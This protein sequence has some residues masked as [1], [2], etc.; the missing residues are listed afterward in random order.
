MSGMMHWPMSRALLL[1]TSFV[2]MT[3]VSCSSREQAA[4]ELAIDNN[5]RGMTEAELFRRLGPA[6]TS[7]TVVQRMYLRSDTTPDGD[8]CWVALGENSSYPDQ[9]SSLS[10]GYF[11]ADGLWT[12]DDPESATHP[13]LQRFQDEQID[14]AW[15]LRPVFEEFGPP[16]RTDDLF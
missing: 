7:S 12:H 1:P 4:R 5:A 13:I 3:M 9:I 6:D 2:F 8:Q 11:G 14:L 10:T 16:D 15:T